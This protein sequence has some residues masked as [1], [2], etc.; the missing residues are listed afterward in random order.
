MEKSSDSHCPSCDD[1]LWAKLTLFAELN[2]D[3]LQTLL[4]QSSRE[5][6]AA[7]AKIIGYGDEGYSMYVILRGSA[8]V[9]VPSPE[10]EVELAV[11]KSG[12]FFGKS[13]WST[14]A[15]ALRM[16]RPWRIVNCSASPA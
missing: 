14:M 4:H 10:G 11:L 8:R 1:A 9:T 16:S 12:D 13:P 6:F 7:G 5:H 3:E 15:R 2:R